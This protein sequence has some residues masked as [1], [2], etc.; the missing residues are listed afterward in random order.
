MDNRDSSRLKYNA[1]AMCR[2]RKSKCDKKQP[3]C[4]LCSRLGKDCTYSAMRKKSGP[5]R[6]VLE[7]LETRLAKVEE[8]LEEKSTSHMLPTPSSSHL[9]KDQPNMP[10]S[11][12]FRMP[13]SESTRFELS[14]FGPMQPHINGKEAFQASHTL[15]PLIP[16]NSSNSQSSSIGLAFREQLPSED[17]IYDLDNIFFEKVYP[18]IPI[19]HPNRFLVNSSLSAHLSLPLSLRYMIWCH[20]ALCCDRYYSFHSEFY[21]C[22]RKYAEVDETTESFGHGIV[23]LSHCQAWILMS[24][25]ELRMVLLPRAWVS[26]GKA[27]S[28]SLIIGLNQLDGPSQS[29][30]MCM[31]P[32]KD[33]VEGEERRRVFWM[34]FCIDQYASIATGRPMLIDETDHDVLMALTDRTQIMTTLPAFEQSFLENKPQRTLQLCEIFASED[35]SSLSSLAYVCVSASLLGRSLSHT[36]QIQTFGNDCGLDEQYWKQHQSYYDIPIRILQRLPTHLRL[37]SSIHDTN[38]VFANLCVHASTIWYHQQV[39]FSSKMCRVLDWYMMGNHHRCLLAAS[40]ITSLTR[41]IGDFDLLKCNTFVPFPLF[42]A[43]RV[44]VLHLESQPNDLTIRSL[45]QYLVSILKIMKSRNPSAGMF[46]SRLNVSN[47]PAS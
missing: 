21:Q 9:P 33:W 29:V 3:R 32:P 17:M 11:E 27:S 38:V 35:L 44:F 6:K 34:A 37:S 23:T 18:S 41:M 45:L 12:T 5:K 28:L 1:C 42:L 24:I 46:L 15:F 13:S 19:I 7:E 8:L 47:A 2:S 16:G 30:K 20:A 10:M 4:S 25:Y 31:P 26:V 14:M 22:A 39:I 43:A 40:Q 36:R